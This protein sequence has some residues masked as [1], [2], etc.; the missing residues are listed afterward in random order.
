M[1]SMILSC[2]LGAIDDLAKQG[3]VKG[4]PKLKYQKDHLCSTCFEQNPPSSTP[5]VL[6]TKN[7]WDILFQPMFD[8]YFNPSPSVV[9][10]VFVV[11][12]PRP[13]DPLGLPSSTSIDQDAPSTSTSSTIQE[14]QSPV[15]FEGVEEQLQPAQFI[16]DFEESFTPVA[17]IKAIRIF[18]ANAINKNMPIYQMD[19]KTTFLNG[20]LRE[21]VYVSQLEGFVD[22]DNPTHVYKLKKALYGL[23][24]GPRAYP[25]GIFINQ[26]KYALEILK[27][28]GMDSSDSV[29]TLM[30]DRT[31]LDKNLQGKTV[32]P[33]HYRG[34]TY[35]KAS[36]TDL[37][38][39][40]RNH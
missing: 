35:R 3:L 4:L 9:S 40:E 26:T 8:E 18:V 14:T 1:A 2:K 39:P 11:A 7:E 20:E 36:E 34:T 10:L 32:D 28:Y 27:K 31:K 22:Q 24:H 30:V 12:A 23:K 17:R 15:I 25:R 16:I 6:P 13:D 19:I 33:T 5:Y 21:E 29:D 37:S 38:I